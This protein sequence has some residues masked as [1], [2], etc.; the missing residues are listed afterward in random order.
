[1]GKALSGVDEQTFPGTMRECSFWPRWPYEN[2]SSSWCEPDVF[3]RF[4]ALDVVIEAKRSDYEQLQYAQQWEN[5]LSTYRNAHKTL[6]GKSL[7][8]LVVGGLGGA[9]KTAWEKESSQLERQFSCK[10]VFLSWA[11]LWLKC[12][13]PVLSNSELSHIQ[14]IREDLRHS[15]RLFGIATE[16]PAPLSSF[17]SLVCLEAMRFSEA[18]A[19]FGTTK[20]VSKMEQDGFVSTFPVAAQRL[21]LKNIDWSAYQ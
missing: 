8:L 21:R 14:L 6:K 15:L 18:A 16:L 19:F 13:A 11:D 10:I 7:I 17:P 9:A 2:N 5:E 4:D 3:C 20:A 12:I 1:M